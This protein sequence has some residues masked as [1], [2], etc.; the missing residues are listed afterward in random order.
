M[1]E[2]WVLAI[3]FY[4]FGLKGGETVRVDEFETNV[5]HVV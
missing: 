1:M 2:T 3:T 5:S 4:V